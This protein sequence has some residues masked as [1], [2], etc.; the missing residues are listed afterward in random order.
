MNRWASVP[1][2]GPACAPLGPKAFKVQKHK[3][4]NAVSV[5]DRVAS[6]LSDRTVAGASSG[7]SESGVGQ[8]SESLGFGPA[9]WTRLRSF[10][11]K[12]FQGA[13]LCYSLSIGHWKHKLPN[14][15]SVSDRVASSRSDRTVAGASSGPSESGVGQASESLGFGPARWTRLRSFRTNSFQGADLCNSLSIGSISC[16]M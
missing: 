15:V 5:S 13:D 12:S 11:T 14:A 6:S 9:R 4:P 2:V 10:R 7:L 1:P 8:A 16:L 3:L